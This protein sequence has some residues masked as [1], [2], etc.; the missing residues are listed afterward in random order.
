MVLVK[1]PGVSGDP[2]SVLPSAGV[3]VPVVFQQTPCAVGVE[4]PKAVIVP[5]PVAVVVPMADTASVVTV[6]AQ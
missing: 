5:F 3:G 2:S 1:A 4:T 6:G